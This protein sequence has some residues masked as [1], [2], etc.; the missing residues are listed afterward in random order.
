MADEQLAQCLCSVGAGWMA[1]LLDLLGRKV[2]SRLWGQRWHLDAAP[3]AVGDGANLPRGVLF[4]IEVLLIFQPF[5]SL[6]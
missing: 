3:V 4:G 2:H 1:A 5:S 6:P